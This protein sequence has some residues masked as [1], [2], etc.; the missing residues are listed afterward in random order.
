MDDLHE[1]AM[2]FMDATSN[3]DAGKIFDR[4]MSRMSYMPDKDTVRLMRVA[5]LHGFRL[6]LSNGLNKANILRLHG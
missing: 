4:V 5:F 3:E 6:G 1:L 2:R